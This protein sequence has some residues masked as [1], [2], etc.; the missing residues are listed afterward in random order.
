MILHLI[1]KLVSGAVTPKTYFVYMSNFTIIE[2]GTVVDEWQ[3]LFKSAYYPGIIL[4]N[5]MQSKMQ[6]V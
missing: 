3:M 4:T 6:K 1:D 5:V 2:E